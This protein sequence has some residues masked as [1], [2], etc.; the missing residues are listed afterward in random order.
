MGSCSSNA[1]NAAR[2]LSAAKEL[3]AKDQELAAAKELA[4]KEYIRASYAI[5]LIR[6]DSI[7]MNRYV[8]EI[9]II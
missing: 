6:N 2:E 1:V 7:G 4:A 5:F 9:S 3:H 8:T